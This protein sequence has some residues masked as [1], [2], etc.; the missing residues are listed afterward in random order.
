[1]ICLNTPQQDRGSR[2]TLRE[3]RIVKNSVVLKDCVVRACKFDSPVHYS[4]R[5]L[6]KSSISARMMPILS[7]GHRCGKSPGID[8]S[9]SWLTPRY[10]Y[11]PHIERLLL[12][13]TKNVS[14]LLVRRRDS[15]IYRKADSSN[16]QE[17]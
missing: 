14:S 15:K 1:M 8:Y 12:E 7:V 11:Q 9:L 3:N 13:T 2:K 5:Y 6:G 17:D 16:H 10:L 4:A